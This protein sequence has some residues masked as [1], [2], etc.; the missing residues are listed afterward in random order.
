MTSPTRYNSGTVGA[1]QTISISLAGTFFYLTVASGPLFV[2]PLGGNWVLYYSGTGQNQAT[3]FPFLQVYNPTPNA[4]T[5]Q[6]VAGSD[7][8]CL[9]SFID[10]RSLS[11]TQTPNVLCIQPWV[12]S[13]ESSTKSLPDLTGL[14]FN[15]PSGK[16]W[17][18]VQRVS[19]TIQV[20]ASPG[21][22]V[23]EIL[24]LAADGA[25]LL[26][27]TSTDTEVGPDPYTSP[28]LTL[29]VSGNLSA[30]VSATSNLNGF[31]CF[32]IYQAVAP[33]SVAYQPPN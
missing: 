21:P 4:V 13:L 27:T 18:A 30:T 12:T 33:N 2:K 9:Y 5:Y 11:D 28:P 29:S 19:V 7:N 3:G 10:R 20:V 14:Q 31:S 8:S 25:S 15:D 17:L 1:G 23:G 22:P 26:Q 32:E 24:L 16:P 6:F